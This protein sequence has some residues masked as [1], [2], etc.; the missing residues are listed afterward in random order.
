MQPDNYHDN[1]KAG[2]EGALTNQHLFSAYCLPG[3]HCT[4]GVPGCRQKRGGRTFQAE[5]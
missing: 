3:L 4:L 5:A 2:R 1:S